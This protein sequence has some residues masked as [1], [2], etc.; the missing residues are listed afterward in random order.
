[1]SE[2]KR[3][4]ERE[5]DEGERERVELVSKIPKCNKNQKN[6]GWENGRARKKGKEIQCR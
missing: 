5:R 3:E 1:M 2:W 4:R 6:P